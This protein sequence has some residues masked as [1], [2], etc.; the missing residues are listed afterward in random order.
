MFKNNMSNNYF[1]FK[2]FV[3]YQDKAAMKVCTDA[4]L[5]AAWVTEK[6]QNEKVKIENILDIGSGT[7]LLSLMLAQKLEAKIDAVEIDEQAAQQAKENFEA[8]PWSGRIS[9]YNSSIQQF[10]STTAYDIIISNPPFFE[11]SLRS[12]NEQKNVAKHSGSLPANELLRVVNTL[13]NP[14]G[15]FAILLP[16]FEF[17]RF[18]LIAKEKQLHLVQ[19]TDIRQTPSHSFFR[20]MGIFS[21]QISGQQNCEAICIKDYDNQYTACFKNLLKDYYLHI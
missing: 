1:R 14:E 17:K 15:I 18:E 8:S 16:Y 21:K 7:G 20:S 13:L 4:C 3:V 5:F 6:M 11:Q 10:N 12:T 9:V 19:K 2:Q